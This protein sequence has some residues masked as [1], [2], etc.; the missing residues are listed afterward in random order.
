MK[1]NWQIRLRNK[2]GGKQCQSIVELFGG[3]TQNPSFSRYS[4]RPKRVR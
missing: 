3:H 1:I 2:V 4:F